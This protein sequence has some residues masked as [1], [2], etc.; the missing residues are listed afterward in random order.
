MRRTMRGAVRLAS[1][2]AVA[3]GLLVAATG[4]L[5]AAA[6]PAAA[7]S[8]NSSSAAQA[9]GAISAGPLGQATFPG[10]SPVTVAHANIAGLLTT[11][12]SY[13]QVGGDERSASVDSISAILNFRTD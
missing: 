3:G 10:T 6:L 7:A 12:A 2:L 9:T 5:V 4:L 8:P 11:G 13:R 1:S